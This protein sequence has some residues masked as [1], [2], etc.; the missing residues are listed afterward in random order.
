MSKTIHPATIGMFVSGAVVLLVSVLVFLGSGFFSHQEPFV[1]YF[2]GS[3]KGLRVGAPV[4]FRGVS[5]G[6]VTDIKVVFDPSDENFQTPVIID[7]S[8]DQVTVKGETTWMPRDGIGGVISELI[9]KGLRAQLELQSLVTGQLQVNLD[10]HPDSPLTVVPG[11][12]PYQ[13]IPTVPSS[14]EELTSSFE[15]IP[16]DELVSDFRE[17]LGGIKEFISSGKIESVFDRTETMI[18]KIEDVLSSIDTEIEPLSGEVKAA[19]RELSVL[20]KAAKLG[21]DDLRDA[22]KSAGDMRGRAVK[23]IDTLDDAGRSMKNLSDFL[24]RNPEALLRGQRRK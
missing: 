2:N 10:F 17:A 1:V 6:R 23:L 24:R 20:I 8:S 13:Q 12:L 22:G 16:F 7:I 19:L 15:N 21:V 11:I 18:G 5:V 4:S 9:Q 3:V 14:I